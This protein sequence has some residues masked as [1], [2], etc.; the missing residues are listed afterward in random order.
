[1]FMMHFHHQVLRVSLLIAASALAACASQPTQTASSKEMQAELA[2]WK[3]LKPGVQRLVAI[4]SELKVLLQTLETAALDPSMELETA[5]TSSNV[6]S[7]VLTPVSFD[8]KKLTVVS[9]D[10]AVNNT[11]Q[12]TVLPN[13]AASTESNQVEQTEPPVQPA[14]EPSAAVIKEQKRFSLQLAS[15]T[16]AGDLE[17][18]WQT[19]QKRY[20][21]TLAELDFHSEEVVVS[22]RTY[23][24]VKAGAFDSYS[25][26]QELCTKLRKS[27][28]SCIVNRG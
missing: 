26:A 10:V 27:G 15:V 19:L 14:S 9:P 4:E 18:T 21:A 3:K 11:Q 7:N 16:K 13:L 20:P 8:D 23:Y 5:A 25:E 28:A 2:E 1:M 22:N 6:Q 24:R 17:A 12:Q